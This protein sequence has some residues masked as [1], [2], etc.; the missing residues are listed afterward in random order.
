[1]KSKDLAKLEKELNKGSE[2]M[3]I[4]LLNFIITRIEPHSKGQE[5]ELFRKILDGIDEYNHTKYSITTFRYYRTIE[6]KVEDIDY[7][8]KF[9]QLLNSK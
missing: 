6:F 9:E 4:K 5:K 7:N 2:N 1:M 3:L 8:D